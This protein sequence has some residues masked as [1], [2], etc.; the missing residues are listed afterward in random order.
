MTTH[1]YPDRRTAELDL[2]TRDLKRDADVICERDWPT[3]GTW[4]RYAGRVGRVG[5]INIDDDYRD[6]RVAYVEIGVKFTNAGSGPTTWFLPV[7]LKRVY[8]AHKAPRSRE[9]RSDAG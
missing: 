7:E 4:S 6:V 3:A 8:S 5:A 2:E 9:R 1:T